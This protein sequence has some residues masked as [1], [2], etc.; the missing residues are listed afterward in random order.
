M[1]R[2]LHWIL[3]GGCVALI[4]IFSP[5]AWNSLQVFRLSDGDIEFGGEARRAALEETEGQ[6]FALS[7]MNGELDPG[8][9]RR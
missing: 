6:E 2:N 3:L 1:S 5:L 4:S 8:Q 9:V 7:E